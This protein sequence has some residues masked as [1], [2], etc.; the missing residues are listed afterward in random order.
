MPVNR[1]TDRRIHRIDRLGRQA[2]S[3]LK[4]TRIEID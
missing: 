1:Q 4:A 2:N 3:N